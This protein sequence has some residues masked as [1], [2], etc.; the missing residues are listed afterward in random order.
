MSEKICLPISDSYALY[1]CKTTYTPCGCRF[2]LDISSL[3]K[4]AKYGVAI[5]DKATDIMIRKREFKDC[6]RIGNVYTA[7]IPDFDRSKHSYTFYCND[8]YMTDL[9]AE[10][11]S[12]KL[13]FG[14]FDASKARKAMLSPIFNWDVDVK[15]RTPYEDSF[16]YMLHVR[17][18]TMHASSKAAHKG[19]FLGVTEKLKYL[20]KL[21]VTAIDIQP[22]YEF[23][24][25]DKKTGR[26]NYWGYCKGYYYTPKSAYAFSDNPCTEFCEMVKAAHAQ[27]IEIIMQMYFPASFER[28]E[29]PYVLEF[30][31]AK[32]HVDGF[33]VMGENMPMSLIDESPVLADTKII[34]ESLWGTNLEN[35]DYYDT[36]KTQKRYAEFND[37]YMYVMRRFLKGDSGIMGEAA[38][39]MRNNPLSYAVINYFDSFNSLTLTDLVSYDH[40]HNDDN[41][42]DNRDG[43][44]YN[45]S[46]NCGEEGP[47][48]KPKI[49]S[50]RRK[51]IKNALIMLF[52][53]S[54]VP[55]IFMGDEMGNTQKGNNNP[56]CHDSDITWLDWKGLK[57]KAS[58]YDFIAGLAKIRKEHHFYHSEKEMSMV[59]LEGNGFPELSYHGESAWIGDTGSY[60]NDLGIMYCEKGKLYYAAINMHWDKNTLSLPRA[61]KN[62]S[63]KI[64]YSTDEAVLSDEGKITLKERT[65]AVVIS[66]VNENKDE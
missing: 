2:S 23:N 51:Q 48:N 32:Y 60:K 33:H 14:N 46:W 10:N 43:N 62:S 29:I 52:M 49:L 6:E 17:G 55:M 34:A 66:E 11:Y 22:C 26:Y 57:R 27:G 35:K 15:P 41:G 8:Y 9:R 44:D 30:W 31:A 21:G 56:Y 13:H 40:K 65:I 16:I 47:S 64:Y 39:K 54:G 59:D 7:I 53:S 3:A 5:Y 45:C 28:R 24:E 50:L 25:N 12:D 42:E 61:P 19:T 20:K 1:P 18:F 4:D 37:S 58:V 63:W 38:S 36:A